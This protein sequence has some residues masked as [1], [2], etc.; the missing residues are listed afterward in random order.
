VI[1]CSFIC[2]NLWSLLQWGTCV[3]GGRIP[4]MQQSPS[5]KRCLMS[6]AG[7]TVVAFRLEALMKDLK[8]RRK[9]KALDRGKTD[10]GTTYIASLSR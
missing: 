6:R 9:K 1:T 8:G 5:L 4:I 3:S 2:R 7:S 10:Q